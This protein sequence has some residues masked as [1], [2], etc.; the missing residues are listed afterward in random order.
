LPLTQRILSITSRTMMRIVILSLAVVAATAVSVGHRTPEYLD[1]V[2]DQPP[3]PASLRLKQQKT[4]E[5]PGKMVENA[6]AFLNNGLLNPTSEVVKSHD[7]AQIAKLKETGH[8]SE[9]FPSLAFV[10]IPLNGGARITKAST[11][12]FPYGWGLETNLALNTMI[13]KDKK[14]PNHCFLEGLPPKEIAPIYGS[15]ISQEMYEKRQV[16]CAVRNPYDRVVA[17]YLSLSQPCD[18]EGLNKWAQTE[19]TAFQK[20][21]YLRNQCSH[22]PQVDYMEGPGACTHPIDYSKLEKDFDALMQENGYNLKLHNE[23]ETDACQGTLTAANLTDHTQRLVQ[24]VYE[25]DFEELGPK[26]GWS[27]ESLGNQIKNFILAPINAL[28]SA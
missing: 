24:V 9:G 28:T 23:E 22:I 19:L 13:P 1:S 20:G 4:E 11:P 26:Y 17:Q 16:F 18:A 12:I 21:D 14:G 2:K 5:T 8:I 7:K 6:K 15:K 3:R 27:E 10:N 25:R